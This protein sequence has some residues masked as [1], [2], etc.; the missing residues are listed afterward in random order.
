[1]TTRLTIAIERG[2][3]DPAKCG[4][5]LFFETDRGFREP[6]HM[7]TNIALGFIDLDGDDDEYLPL[8][9]GKRSPQCLAAEHEARKGEQ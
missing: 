2:T 4:T 8:K 5:C 3:E 7:C 9:D 6:V 1:M